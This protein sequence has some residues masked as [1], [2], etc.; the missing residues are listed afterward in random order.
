MKHSVA[1]RATALP[2]RPNPA[3]P[4][5]RPRSGRQRRAPFELAGADVLRD[6]VFGYGEDQRESVL[7]DGV[8][9][10][11]GVIV[12]AVADLRRRRAI[13]RVIPDPRPRAIT[14]LRMLVRLFRVRPDP[15]APRP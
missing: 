8:L 13:D 9:I 7:G 14:Q 15:A 10:A 3:M 11:P 12:T 2:I 5:V 6:Q 4:R 1:R